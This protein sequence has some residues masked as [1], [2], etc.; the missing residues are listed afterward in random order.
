MQ[1][2]RIASTV[3]LS[4]VLIG[5]EPVKQPAYLA[6]DSFDFKTLLGEPPTDCS[7]AHKQEIDELLKMQA[8]R[9]PAEAARVDAEE[10][11]DAFFFA[12]VMGKD[13]NA[14]ALPVTAELLKKA[15]KR[16]TVVVNAAKATFNRNRPYVDEP[17]LHPSVELEKSKSYPSGHAARGMTWGLILSELYPNDREILIARGKQYGIDRNIGGVHYPSD[18]KAGQKLAAEIFKRMLADPEFKADLEKA[19]EECHAVVK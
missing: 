1:W 11:S 9:T 16:A 6:P 4:L 3:A 7:D 2:I 15:T 19:K 13:F 12:D 8:E 10:K 18:V 14:E 17:R 5:A